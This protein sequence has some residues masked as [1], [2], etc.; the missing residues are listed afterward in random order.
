VWAGAL[1]WRRRHT[2]RLPSPRGRPLV[3]TPPR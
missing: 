3:I 1:G 2:T